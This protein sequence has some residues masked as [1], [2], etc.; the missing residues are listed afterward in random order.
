MWVEFV[1]GSSLFLAPGPPVFL[2]PQKPIFQIPNGPRNSGQE[3]PPSG[4]SIAKFPFSITIEF[5]PAW[6]GRRGVELGLRF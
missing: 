4:M 6:F 1:V 3:E 5:F 2:P